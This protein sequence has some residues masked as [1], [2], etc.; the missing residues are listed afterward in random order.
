MN[1]NLFSLLLLSFFLQSCTNL[2]QTKRIPAADDVGIIGPDEVL[3]YYREG[4]FIIVK[5]CG[6]N[7]ILGDTP[8]QARK[9]CDGKTNK[10]PIETFKQ[11]LHDMVSPYRMDVLKPLTPSEVIAAKKVALSQEQIEALKLELE[12]INKF[13]SAYGSKNANLL[14]KNE[15][16]EA[17]QNEETRGAVLK[18][19]E[20]EVGKAIKVIANPQKLTLVKFSSSKDQFL[21]TVLKQFDPYQKFPCGLSGT[22]EERIK[23]CSY[24]SGADKERFVL[25]TRSKEFKEVHKDLAT[26]LV[27]SDRLKPYFD[28]Y[29]AEKAC[30]SKLKEIAG[31]SELKWKLPSI[32]DFREAEKSGIRAALPNMNY[33]FWSSSLNEANSRFAWLYV[34]RDGYIGYGVKRYSGTGSVRCVA[35]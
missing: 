1:F 2:K 6:T 27:W 12:Q 20:A 23:D 4:G 10:V 19:I 7:T 16:I 11:A 22:I 30:H 8:A 24:Q 15:I 14:R 34:G 29:E 13:I 17:L 18:K 35:K 33:W 26:G 21:F 28:H 25:V 3:L 5:S 31:L 32:E 9:N